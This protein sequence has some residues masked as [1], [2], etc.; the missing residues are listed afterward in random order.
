M[1]VKR[2]MLSTLALL[3][4]LALVAAPCGAQTDGAA[5][6]KG[7]KKGQRKMNV[8]SAKEQAEGWQLLFNGKDFTNWRGLGQAEGQIP[9]NFKVEKGQIHKVAAKGG[10][11]D[12]MT[13]KGYDSFELSFEWKLSEGGNNGIKYNVSEEMSTGPS[14]KGRASLGFE[15]QVLDDAKHSDG[16]LKT[17]QCGALYELV[18]PDDAKKQVKP[19]GQWNQSRIVY[20]GNHIEHWLNG[21]KIVEADL[22]TPQMNEALAKSKWKNIKGFGDRRTDGHICI[23]DHQDECWY[24]NIKI[25]ELPRK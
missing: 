18:A 21:Q 12:L 9:Q 1:M 20:N 15:Y 13:V 6:P 16:K 10:N 3:C 4:A 8:L 17:H 2:M 11:G 7:K 24:R 19:I 14:K 22:G 23:T 25:K 5:A